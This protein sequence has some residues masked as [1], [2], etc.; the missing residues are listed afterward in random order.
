M[1][2]KLLAVSYKST[3]G[4]TLL[5]AVVLSYCGCNSRTIYCCRWYS[6]QKR[7]LESRTRC[8]LCSLSFLHTC[9]WFDSREETK[10]TSQSTCTVANKQTKGFT[11]TKNTQ[12][13]RRSYVFS[14]NRAICA[15]LSCVPP[16]SL[17]CLVFLPW[18]GFFV[19]DIPKYLS[20]ARREAKFVIVD[21]WT[22][23]NAQGVW[24]DGDYFF[25]V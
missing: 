16:L 11:A 15:F 13:Q 14:L 24:W 25:S 2:A 20:K 6:T 22:K 18:L 3:H 9:R 23:S 17:S 1:R 10:K 21:D 5:Q 7:L 12:T 8:Q 19:F 4:S